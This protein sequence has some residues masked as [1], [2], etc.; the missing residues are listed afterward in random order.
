MQQEVWA[1]KGVFIW[2]T[3]HTFLICLKKN[4]AG[5]RRLAMQ[6]LTDRKGNIYY[7]FF[8][9]EEYRK[10]IL[11]LYLFLIEDAMQTFAKLFK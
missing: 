6:P 1:L 4:D 2:I 10:N 3:C 8:L 7:Y 9:A 11:L 5:K